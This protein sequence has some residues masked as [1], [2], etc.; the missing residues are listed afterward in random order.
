MSHLSLETLARLVD[1][2]APPLEAA[3]LDACAECRAELDQLRE[4]TR[5]LA[6]LP[7]WAP[8]AHGWLALEARLRREG[9]VRAGSAA[10]RRT[11]FPTV[12]R[13]AAALT[14]FL[15]GT[16]AG[17]A[18]R[19]GSDG[20]GSGGLLAGSET[21]GASAP[22]GAVAAETPEEAARALRDAEVAY[23]GALARHA[24]L[25]R[26]LP[27]T[28]PVARLAALEGIVLTTRA[29]LRQAPA[30][31]V[32]NG[33]HLTAVAQREAMLRQLALAADQS[34]F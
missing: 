24:R 25:T 28:D 11:R 31:P 10:A 18:L 6:G 14:L 34:W 20:R 22:A 8:P 29:A 17:A 21:E 9:L 30:D 7:E 13:L 26:Q 33:Y 12:L 23:L 2:A 27:S 4:Q 5:A 32:I 19:A 15:L 16:L 1:E 3:H